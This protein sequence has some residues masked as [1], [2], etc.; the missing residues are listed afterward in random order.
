MFNID[1]ECTYYLAIPNKKVTINM[2]EIFTTIAQPKYPKRPMKTGSNLFATHFYRIYDYFVSGGVRDK[3]KEYH[4]SL[5]ST[6]VVKG[7]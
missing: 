6:D 4:L 2:N 5:S 7:D 1:R 3:I